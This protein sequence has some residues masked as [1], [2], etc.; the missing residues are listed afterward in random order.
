MVYGD[1]WPLQCAVSYC[2]RRATAG[3]YCARHQPDREQGTGNREQP[4]YMHWTGYRICAACGAGFHKACECG[5][6]RCTCSDARRAA[7]IPP[8][9]KPVAHG[10]ESYAHALRVA[11]VP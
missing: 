7:P 6:C 9:R 3:F 11:V 2:R 10:P 1:R 4:L 8:R 5:G